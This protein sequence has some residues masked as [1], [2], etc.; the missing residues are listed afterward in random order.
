VAFGHAL[1]RPAESV[2]VRELHENG[3][4]PPHDVMVGDDGPSV[5]EKPAPPPLVG[6]D[7][8][9]GLDGETERVFEVGG[10]LFR[11]RGLFRRRDR[12][13]FLFTAIPKRRE[14]DV[15]R[16]ADEERGDERE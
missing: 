2:S 9:H 3:P 10:R 16:G 12:R 13:G 11:R 7:G 1:H 15:A 14:S 6:E 5:D 4:A 8:D